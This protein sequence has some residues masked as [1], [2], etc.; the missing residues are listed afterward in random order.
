M[1]ENGKSMVISTKW[2]GAAILTFVIGFSILGFLAYR[3]YD[4]SPPIPT[5]VVSQDGKILFSGADIMTGQHIFQK[6]GLMQYGTIFGHGAYLGPDFTA[7][8][9][10]RAAL[11]MVDFHRQAGRS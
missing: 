8:Y 2:L 3:V 4:E 6:Y 1:A 11:L 9:L 10:H 7:Q 5:E